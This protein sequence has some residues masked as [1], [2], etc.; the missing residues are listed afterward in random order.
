MPGRRGG[1][2]FQQAQ[3]GRAAGAGGGDE[4]AGTSSAFTC[5]GG[6]TAGATAAYET[7]G[8]GGGAPHHAAICAAATRSNAATQ[9]RSFHGC[10]CRAATAGGKTAGT[11]AAATTASRL[12]AN[13]RGDHGD[14]GDRQHGA[15]RQQ[16]ADPVLWPVAVPGGPGW[17]VA[18]PVG[19]ATR[20]AGARH[21][22][23][24]RA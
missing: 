20:S 21:P 17:P 7:Q 2:L 12:C 5:A 16:R 18:G 1:D 24:R 8:C 14:S 6:K 22:E 11:T 23:L 15:A 10:A 19:T 3:A 9:S 4:G 13:G